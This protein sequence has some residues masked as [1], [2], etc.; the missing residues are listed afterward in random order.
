[1]IDYVITVN[2]ALNGTQ[3]TIENKEGTLLFIQLRMC[4][5]K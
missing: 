4:F 1:M 2:K 5:K 3:D